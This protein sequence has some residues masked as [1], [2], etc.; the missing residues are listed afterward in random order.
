MTRSG[1]TGA[2]MV[3]LG[4]PRSGTTLL[5]R[6]L[7]A[8]SDIA[9][10]PETFLFGAAARF[11]ES[12]LTAGGNDVGVLAAL[13]YLGF[14]DD[15]TLARLRGLCFGFLDEYADKCGKVRW[16]EKTAL[17]AFH[18]DAIERICGDHVHYI[19]MVRH[20]F[21]VAASCIEFCDAMGTYPPVLHAYVRQWPQPLEAFVRSWIDVTKALVAL[22]EHRADRVIVLRY[23]DLVED[24][25]GVIGDLLEF[26]DADPAT[27]FVASALARTGQLGF[28]DHKTYASRDVHSQAVERWRSL[29]EPQIRRL[30]PL[31]EDWLDLLGYPK[32]DAEPVEDPTEGRRRYLHA[33]GAGAFNPDD[34]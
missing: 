5:R 27:D 8:H 24:P 21:S 25:E 19:G 10:P 34:G 2:G 15:E 26:V 11:I 12:T 22:G 14:D 1:R 16:A 18:I 32:I 17:D 3:I 28:S 29:P 4:H 6:L 9:A 31:V 33:L 30:A 13:D 20:P 7:D 23:E